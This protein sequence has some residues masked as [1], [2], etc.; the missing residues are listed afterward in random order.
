MKRET[1]EH[2]ACADKFLQAADWL[3]S[4]KYYDVA[5]GRAYY[6]MFHAATAAL[7]ERDIRRR[8]HHGTISAFGDQF[9]KTGVV[10]REF[11][12][13]FHDAFDAR[14]DSD[15]M[16]APGIST[17]EARETLDRARRFVEICRQLCE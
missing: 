16:S 14:L 13:Y 6:A 8:S 2:L 9:I 12:K 1:E 15:Y 5:L 17:A 11:H 3:V 4:G 10:P 7:E